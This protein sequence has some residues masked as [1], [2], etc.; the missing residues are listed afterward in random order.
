MIIRMMTMMTIVV[1]G[2]V[3]GHMN[4]A[5]TRARHVVDNVEVSGRLVTWYMC[6]RRSFVDLMRG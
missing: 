6:V 5:L 4:H 1:V 3:A 2:I